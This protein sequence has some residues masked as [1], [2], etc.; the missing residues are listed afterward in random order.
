[1]VP[2]LKGLNAW[3]IHEGGEFGDVISRYEYLMQVYTAAGRSYR[4]TDECAVKSLASSNG[5][6]VASR[7]RVLPLA[8]RQDYT[9]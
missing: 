8:H 9:L 4:Y 2:V 5:K 1:M 7:C 3:L 6:L